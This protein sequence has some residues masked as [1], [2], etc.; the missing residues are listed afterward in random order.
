MK[1]KKSHFRYLLLPALFIMVLLCCKLPVFIRQEQN[2]LA[3]RW[4]SFRLAWESKDYKLAYRELDVN[5]IQ[6]LLLRRPAKFLYWK[7][8][9]LEKLGKSG[10]A[11]SLRLVL[12]KKY[13]ADY[14]AFLLVP[15]TGGLTAKNF[16]KISQKSKKKFQT[17]YKAEVSA[18]EAKTGVDSALVWAV[19]KRES[20]F[21]PA[22]KSNSGALGLMQIMPRTG[23]EVAEKYGMRHY[24]LRKPRDNILLGAFQLRALLRQFDGDVIYSAAAYNAGASNVFAWRRK[25]RSR[26]EWVESIPYPETREFIRCVYENY[27]V[28][29]L[30]ASRNK[31]D[32][33]EQ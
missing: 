7:A 18:A 10:E 16:E 19:M 28:Y 6:L 5:G 23:E 31:L 12:L 14:Y 29:K 2:R 21:N 22:A 27:A 17:P 4:N 20:K 11:K 15:E 30:L 8:E 3:D 13:P 24:D 26:A 32:K 1:K 33:T 9:T 25:S